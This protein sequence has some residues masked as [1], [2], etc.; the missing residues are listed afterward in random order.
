MWKET[1]SLRNT[2]F[3]ICFYVQN[4]KELQSCLLVLDGPWEIFLFERLILC[5]WLVIMG[6]CESL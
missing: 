1:Q 3:S 5:V 2:F 4:L 6:D